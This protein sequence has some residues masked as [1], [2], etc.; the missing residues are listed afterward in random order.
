MKKSKKQMLLDNTKEVTSREQNKYWRWAIIKV[1][2]NYIQP[3]ENN[4]IDPINGGFETCFPVFMT[5]QAAK[6]Y[7]Q[8]KLDTDVWEEH[9][10]KDLLIVKLHYGVS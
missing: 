7:I 9:F 1:T 10:T 4:M 2:D 6:D 5:R 8:N 3:V